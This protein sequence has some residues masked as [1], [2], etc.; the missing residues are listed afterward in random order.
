MKMSLLIIDYACRGFSK[1]LFSMTGGS[2][3]KR[4]KRKPFHSR[5][6]NSKM[7]NEIYAYKLTEIL[8]TCIVHC[9][10]SLIITYV[11]YIHTKQQ[12]SWINVMVG[13]FKYYD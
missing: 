1:A 12:L 9:F 7:L 2:K 8:V 3:C 5:T 4:G 11:K 6:Q 13:R 10:D